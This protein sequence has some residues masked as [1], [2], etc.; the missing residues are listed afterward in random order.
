MFRRILLILLGVVL[1]LLI[2]A[3]GFGFYTVRQSFPRTDG[4]ISLSSL[5][6]AV[7]IYR[8]PYGIPHIYATTAHDLFFSQGY[9]HAQDRFWQMD[10]WRHISSGRLSEMFGESQLET[11]QFLRTLGWAR[12]AS[13]EFAA[14]N[15]S[16]QAVMQ[17]YADGVNAYLAEH[18]GSALSLEYAVLKL[19][20]PDYQ[21][22]PWQPEHSLAWAKVMAWDLGEGQMSAE[23]EM[24]RLLEF[25]TPE[26]VDEI[27]PPYPEE[28][29]VI[30]PGYQAGTHTPVGQENLDL[31]AK[32]APL[33]SE[34][35][36]RTEGVGG[37]L[38]TQSIGN[39]DGIGSNNWVVAGDRTASGM[40]L[41]A[42]DM[43]LGVQM[44]AIWYEVG[45]YCTPKSPECPY[46]VTGYSFAGV[47]GVVVG[48]NDRVAWGF[49]NV[50][51]DVADLYIEKINP[52][53][54]GQYEV[55]GQWVDM[56]ILQETIQVA[57]GE[58]VELVVRS[59]RHGPLISGLYGD[60]TDLDEESDLDL[61]G[62]YAVALRWTALQPTQIIKA[63][64]GYNRAQNWEEFRQAASYFTVPSQNTVYADVDG[65]I[66]Y[67]TPGWIPIRNPQHTGRLPV[68]GWTDENEWQGYI[69]FEE[70][71]HT[72]NPPQGYVATANNAVV[73]AE[74]PYPISYYWAQGYRARRIVEMIESAPV[75]SRLNICS[76]CT[77]IIR[78]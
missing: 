58:P 30:L 20:T 36:G 38:V 32:L 7:D 25:L 72:F 67:Q 29:P 61:D 48:H 55:N 57:G 4:E 39:R 49:T 44:P 16:E 45:L 12:I 35:A 78:T 23:I 9:I 24:A 17:A 75:Q 19:L 27:I 50:G 6:G 33:F 37:L 53:N 40:P 10:F 77:A 13:Q 74:Y 21:P 42:N 11:D 62:E 3:A 68:P 64:L 8:D 52:Q 63:I 15:A 59:T 46:Q 34:M 70:L 22:E 2:L 41:L 14:M 1:L 28:H 60:L 56:D 76:R 47:P 26:Q 51:P 43:H 54:P 5:D 18:Q 31:L 69:P 65:N 71:P 66:G 73:S